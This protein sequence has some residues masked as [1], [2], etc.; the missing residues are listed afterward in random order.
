M[1]IVLS[2]HAPLRFGSAS[3]N[4]SLETWHR[5]SQNLGFA[6][7]VAQTFGPMPPGDDFLMLKKL[8]PMIQLNS[9]ETTETTEWHPATTFEQGRREDRVPLNA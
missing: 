6:R 7:V 1:F 8:E 5:A 3:K 2:E 4:R 9:Q